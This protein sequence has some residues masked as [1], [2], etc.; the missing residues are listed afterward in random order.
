MLIELSE[1]KGGEVGV[2]HVIGKLLE[3]TTST[4]C[5]SSNGLSGNKE[6]A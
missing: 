4:L 5:P 2:I 1:E 3:Q 6:L